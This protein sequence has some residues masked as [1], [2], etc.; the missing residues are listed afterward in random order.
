MS[1]FTAKVV[2]LFCA[3]L[4]ALAGCAGSP[5]TAAQVGDHRITDAEVAPIAAALAAAGTDK[6][7]ATKLTPTVISLLIQSELGHAA[8]VKAGLNFTDNDR[9]PLYASNP[10]L[11]AMA[12]QPATAAFIQRYAD[13][14][15]VTQSAEGKTAFSDVVQNTKITVNPRYGDWDPAQLQLTNAGGSLSE[16]APNK[17]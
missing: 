2:A 12:T 10:V 13:L 15:L 1:K 3:G 6:E 17:P 4:L 11:G 14:Y 5:Q 8:M 16:L 7:T 9:K